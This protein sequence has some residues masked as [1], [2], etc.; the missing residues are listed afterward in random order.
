MQVFIL[1]HV[2]NS[3]ANIGMLHQESFEHFNQRRYN[4]T[5]IY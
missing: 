2:D 1:Q 5:I 3:I 4:I